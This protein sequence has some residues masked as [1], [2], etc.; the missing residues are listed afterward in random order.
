MLSLFTTA[1]QR[2]HLAATAPAATASGSACSSLL[3]GVGGLLGEGGS[4]R[5]QVAVG[6]GP[7]TRFHR[8]RPRRRGVSRP[9]RRVGTTSD[10]TMRSVKYRKDHRLKPN[11]HSPGTKVQSAS[12]VRARSQLLRP[13]ASATSISKQAVLLCRPLPGSFHT[14]LLEGTGQYAGGGGAG[15]AGGAAMSTNGLKRRAVSSPRAGGPSGAAPA[16]PPRARARRGGRD[17]AHDGPSPCG[18][19][20][21]LGGVWC[22]VVWSFSSSWGTSRPP[23]PRSRQGGALPRRRPTL[24]PP[25]PRP[26]SSGPRGLGASG[27]G[28]G[29]GLR[30][31]PPSRS[32]RPRLPGPLR[33]PPLQRR[34]TRET[35]GERT[36]RS[37]PR[38]RSTSA[39]RGADSPNAPAGASL[40]AS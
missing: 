38:A 7:S 36:A 4:E 10:G 16:A 25:P 6:V 34:G 24:A 23:S 28:R 35:P 20:G 21:G 26:R 29:R 39:P 17:T 33:P 22:G 27:P 2:L 32:P 18:G 9:Q 12:R 5:R 40:P 8:R 31:P 3:E 19:G 14:R 1:V 13:S 15:G 37:G 30:G 11:H